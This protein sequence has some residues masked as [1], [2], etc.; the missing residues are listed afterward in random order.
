MTGHAFSQSRWRVKHIVA[1]G[2]D[3]EG[4]VS[5]PPWAR[6]GAGPAPIPLCDPPNPLCP[7]RGI[8]SIHAVNHV[9]F[10][11]EDGS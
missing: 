2:I 4:A 9:A 3:L 10:L 6:P 8:R 7:G 1:H 11:Q 5:G